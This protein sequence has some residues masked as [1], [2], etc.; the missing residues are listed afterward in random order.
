MRI[1]F[2]AIM[3]F[4][5]AALFLTSCSETAYVGE[6]P[7][8]DGPTLTVSEAVEP[9]TFGRT[10]RVQGTVHQVCQEE[11]CWMSITD[12]T[13][14]LRMTFSEMTTL[15]PMDLAG[16][17]IVEGV[18]AEEVYEADVAQAI[19]PSIGWT[20]D[21]IAAV[22]GDQRLPMMTATGVL[23]LDHQP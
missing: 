9:T 13:S 12:G 17:V 6:A 23:F 8:D 1:S 18:V 15:V 22:D 20:E 21:Q 4:S 14:Y 16:D 2:V 11:G 19:G 10:I 3:A 5:L 7:S